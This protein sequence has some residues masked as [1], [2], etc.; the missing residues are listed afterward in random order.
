MQLGCF[1]LLGPI[2]F[3]SILQGLGILPVRPTHASFSAPAFKVILSLVQPPPFPRNLSLGN[4]LTYMAS[5]A[6]SPTVLWY[7]HQSLWNK[8]NSRMRSYITPALPTP[9]NPDL[10]SIGTA[11]DQKE[12]DKDIPGLGFRREG[13]NDL[14]YWTFSTPT[15]AEQDWDKIRHPLRAFTAWYKH[16]IVDKLPQAATSSK[17][18]AEAMNDHNI[19]LT[20][21]QLTGVDSDNNEERSGVVVPSRASIGTR[22]PSPEEVS[23]VDTT[24]SRNGCYHCSNHSPP[25]VVIGHGRPKLTGP[26]DK[27]RPSHR[28]THLSSALV[29]LLTT[30]LSEIATS[31]LLL[32]LETL[33]VRSVARAY[34]L[35]IGGNPS[36]AAKIRSEIYPL[37]SWFGTGLRSGGASDYARRMACCFGMETLIAY[38]F[39]QINAG[40][41]W[42]AG[43]VWF[44]WGRR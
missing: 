10:I 40:V 30:S 33:F 8:V 19:T 16:A 25:Y 13:D 5:L 14:A 2:K 28:V 43:K 21:T 34:I 22:S 20:P 31:I 12:D 6:S 7:L 1:T 32:P 24:E 29:E 4:I 3:H 15:K 17:H 42:F 37:Q 35:K 27:S 36:S 23:L 41:V 39:W 11:I 26:P 9:N 38:G 44:N 18:T